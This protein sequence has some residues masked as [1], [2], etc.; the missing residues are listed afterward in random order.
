MTPTGSNIE[1][2]MLSVQVIRS[3]VGSVI[4]QAQKFSFATRQDLCD[5]VEAA[6]GQ[7]ELQDLKQLP[8]LSFLDPQP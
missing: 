2:T 5:P 8:H 4:I 1:T 7:K 6:Q 3:V